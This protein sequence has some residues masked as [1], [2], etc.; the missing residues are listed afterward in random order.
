MI[1]YIIVGLGLAGL[2]F[3][4][5]LVENDKSFIVFND[6]S[7]TSSRVAGGLFNPVILK[8]F[9][10]SWKAAEQV[11]VSRSFYEGL[12]KRLHVKI[13][14]DLTILRRLA[15]IE[16]QNMWF[17]ATDKPSLK[18]FLS[19]D[20]VQNT[21]SAVKAPFALGKVLQSARI[22]CSTLLE[23]YAVFL[24]E[25]NRL[26][27]DTFSYQQLTVHDHCITYKNIKAK[28][29]VFTEGYGVL[30][31]PFFNYLPLQGSKGEYVIIEAI[32]LELT[33]AVK[34]SV[35]I[36]PLGNNIYKVGAN[37]SHGEK[38]NKPTT[39]ARE[40]LLEQL[41]Q[42]I[43][44]PYTVL[45]Q[46]AGVRPTVIDRRPLLGAHP[47]HKG[48]WVFNGMGSHGILMA[49]WAANLLFDHIEKGK[50]LHPEM[51]IARFHGRYQN[52]E[53]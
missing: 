22:S 32:D 6:A 45:D 42:L 50:D 4:E 27:D 41:E 8:R 3:C 25:N 29:V 48:L 30:Q 18:P 7:Q 47:E 53:F 21:N 31:N 26:L 28:N 19:P 17:E 16:E 10:L 11:E 35:F 39:S 23:Q 9:N 46:V 52:Q 5:K 12:E 40:Q 51:N 36:I 38:S 33:V 20:L 43:V 1:D 2:S 24:R 14:Q 37:Y 34:S 44:T 13:K 49:P 15:S